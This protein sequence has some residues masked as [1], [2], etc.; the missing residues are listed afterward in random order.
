MDRFKKSFIEKID[1]PK[2]DRLLGQSLHRM[3]SCL[4]SHS[5]IIK[6]LHRKILE[7][8]EIQKYPNNFKTEKA[9]SSP[10]FQHHPLS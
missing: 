5:A 2:D 10:L 4:G 7:P 9:I 3:S 1:I 6:L 8:T